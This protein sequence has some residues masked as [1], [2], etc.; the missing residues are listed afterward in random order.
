[1]HI[2][3]ERQRGFD[4]IWDRFP[5]WQNRHSS[6]WWYFLLMP[7]QEQGFG[8]KQ[9]M[10][11][12][13]TKVG[14]SLAINGVWHQ[15]LAKNAQPSG[16]VEQMAGMTVGWIYD[17]RSMHDE[18]VHQPAPA[19]LS[20]DGFITAW[21]EMENGRSYGC[22]MRTLP[23][24]PFG[25]HVQVEGPKGCA[26]FQVWGDPES[27]I[28][29]PD[30]VMS[31]TTSFGGSQVV[32]WKHLRFQGEFASPNGVEQLEGIGYFQRVCLNIHPF[33]WKWIWVA[34][35]DETVFSAFSPYFGLNVFRRETWYLP[36]WL[37]QPSIPIK[38]SS[39]ISTAESRYQNTLLF[40]KT[41]I[42]PV[43]NGRKYPN[44]RVACHSAN[45][46]FLE[47]TAVS[48]AHT[49]F[50]LDEKI[51]ANLLRSRFNYNEYLFKVDGLN[52]RINGKP[53]TSHTFGPGWGNLEY[54]WGLGA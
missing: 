22:E 8:P 42:I 23:D 13:L 18:L 45:G 9:M 32:A 2:S 31:L 51:F 24:K 38:P 53:I 39:Y 41:R 28:T 5:Q 26:N 34:F 40:D 30:D 35:E 10:F 21:A 4:M 46:D 49:Q 47:Y 37:E 25:I 3:P 20:K 6:A 15:G 43:T 17:G 44:F 14:D 16:T 7:R 48:H 11:T 29:A 19:T 27:E 12:F 33:P 1:M 36:N 54:T 50:L 52:G